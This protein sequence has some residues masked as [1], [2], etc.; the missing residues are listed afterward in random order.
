MTRPSAAQYH[1]VIKRGI[2]VLDGL[3]DAQQSESGHRA[4]RYHAP[5]NPA[6]FW[7]ARS[8]GYHNGPAS[9][10]ER[11]DSASSVNFLTASRCASAT[12]GLSPEVA[13]SITRLSISLSA[14]DRSA[15]F[16]VLRMVNA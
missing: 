11:K 5:S 16:A 4:S 14:V 9:R 2:L 1:T 8:V 12:S 13:E 3:G 10:D 7:A 15:P 6:H